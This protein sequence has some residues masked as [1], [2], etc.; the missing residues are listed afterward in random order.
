MMERNPMPCIDAEARERIAELTGRLASH[1]RHCDER[2]AN[3][4]EFMA[5]IERDTE[6]IH[7][8]LGGI[9]RW[10]MSVMLLLIV[11]LL[12]MASKVL[13]QAVLGH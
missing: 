11:S 8:R 10:L 13:I 1:E 3:L 2:H 4:R 9:W 5:Q 6:R 12:G 7:E